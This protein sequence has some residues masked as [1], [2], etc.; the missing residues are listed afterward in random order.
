MTNLKACEQHDVLWCAVPSPQGAVSCGLDAQLRGVCA[1]V[2]SI[3]HAPYMVWLL[4][5][6]EKPSEGALPIA[7]QAL[8]RLRDRCCQRCWLAEPVVGLMEGWV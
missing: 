2:V 1:R 5:A 6:L 8:L 4:N 3:V 7:E